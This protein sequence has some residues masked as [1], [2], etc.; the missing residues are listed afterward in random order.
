MNPLN[1]SNQ[2]AVAGDQTGWLRSLPQF[3][4][5]GGFFLWVILG[6][7]LV[8]LVVVIL[9][10]GWMRRE[11]LMPEGLV[12][13]LRDAED[14]PTIDRVNGQIESNRHDAPLTGIARTAM[15][16]AASGAKDMNSAVEA[17]A[18]SEVMRMQWGLG[19]LEVI[20]VIA[21]LL[22]LLGTAAGLVDV[23]E[24]IGGADKDVG[25]IALGIGKALSTTIAGLAVAVPSVIAH[26]AFATQVER[27]ALEMEMLLQNLTSAIRLNYPG[28]A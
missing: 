21:P 23:F 16:A 25:L 9:R 18:R 10:L 12:Q 5:E 13:A 22:G 11:H 20:I 24:G 27:W 8:T 7:G 15:E 26:S 4:S 3:L 1:F 14:I 6:C 28:V 2:L 17:R 19:M